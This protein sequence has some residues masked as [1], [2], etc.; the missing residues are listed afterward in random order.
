MGYEAGMSNIFGDDNTSYRVPEF[1]PSF[2]LTSWLISIMNMWPFR[3]LILRGPQDMRSTNPWTLTENYSNY[4][5]WALIKS[6]KDS[7]KKFRSMNRLYW[8]ISCGNLLVWEGEKEA[9]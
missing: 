1:F 2:P 6:R 3:T 5:L 7:R 8:H 9:N 4:L